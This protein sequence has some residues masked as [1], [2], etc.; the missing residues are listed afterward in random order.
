ML[1]HVTPENLD[2]LDT[3]LMAVGAVATFACPIAAVYIQKSR[4]ILKA[5]ITYMND[6]A[7]ENAKIVE[8]VKQVSGKDMARKVDQMLYSDLSVKVDVRDDR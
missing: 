6:N 5:I 4:K 7:E 1:E 3:V 2:T 8:K